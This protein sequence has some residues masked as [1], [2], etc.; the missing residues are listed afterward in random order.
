MA[1]SAYIYMVRIDRA[2]LWVGTVKHEMETWLTHHIRYPHHFLEIVRWEDGC[3]MQ[4][5][6]RYMKA[7]HFLERGCVFPKLPVKED[8]TSLTTLI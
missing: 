6:A 3:Q 7:N 8:K 4:D 1:R 5:T 2:P